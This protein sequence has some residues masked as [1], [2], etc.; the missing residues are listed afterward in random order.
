M[1]KSNNN[2]LLASMLLCLMFVFSSCDD[3]DD[4]TRNEVIFDDIA[5]TGEPEVQTNPVVTDGEGMLDAIYNKDTNVL[6][7]TIT[8]E[9]GNADDKTTGMHFHGPASLTESA[10]V[11]IPI[12]LSTDAPMGSITGETRALTQTEEDQ[13]LSGM[14]YLNI[15]SS[16][17]P[18]GELRGQLD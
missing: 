7:Y 8:W 16:T 4:V 6:T 3:D 12:Q 15:H 2:W 11:V 13:L 14:W 10:G 9:L 5:L 1:K 18:G 17:Y